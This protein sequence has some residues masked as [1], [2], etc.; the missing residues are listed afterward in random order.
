MVNFLLG[1][2]GSGKTTEI[3]KN[4]ESCVQN[5]ETTFLLVPEQQVYI[6]ECMLAD[7]PATSARYLQVISF[8]TLGEL[9]FSKYGGLTDKAASN[10]VRT[11]V[12]WHTLRCAT[13]GE[14]RMLSHYRG[15]KIDSAF[16][17][18]MLS[19][20]DELRAN[21]ITPKMCEE[22]S[23][24]CDDKALSDKLSDIA[25]IYQLF[26]YNI[27]ECAGEDEANG[28]HKLAKLAS[29][30]ESHDFFADTN[31]FIDSFTSFTKEELNI[32]KIIIS[33]AKNVCITLPYDGHSDE[34]H[35]FSIS[36][37]YK[38]LQ[39]YAKGKDIHTRLKKSNVRSDKCE[40]QTLEKDLW[41]FRI[42]KSS[43]PE[44]S[45]SDRGNIEMYKCKNEY[46]EIWLAGLNIKKELARGVKCSEIALIT[47]NPEAKRGIISAVFSQLKIPY[48]LSERTDLSTTAPA[49]LILSTLRCISHGF[50]SVDVMTLLKTGFLNVKAEDA[51][52]FEDYC[53]TW[54]ISGNLFTVS[55]PWSMN[56][57][58]YTTSEN[59]R[60]RLI[61][62][63]ANEVRNSVISPL[64]ELRN[65]FTINKGNT[66][67]NCRAL[68]AY[69][70]KIK[71]SEQIVTAAEKAMQKDEIKEAGELLRLYDCIISALSDTARVL[72]KA[73]T[74]AEDL[75]TALDIMLR[76][77]D[78]GSVPAISDY[79]TVG[80]AATLRIENIKTAILVGLCEGE[81]PANLSDG[82]IL[83]ETDKAMIEPIVNDILG[84]EYEKTTREVNLAQHEKAI[85]S[86]ELFYVY[87]SM[88]KPSEKLI[89]S[90]NNS[91]V[92][93]GTH[94]PSSA[95]NRITF[96]FPYI[97]PLSFDLASVRAK[98]KEQQQ[99]DDEKKSDSTP[100]ENQADAKDE[101]RAND[102]IE[103]YL[104]DKFFAYNLFGDK[105]SLNKSTITE[106]NKCPYR[107]WC[108]SIL[109]LREQK[110]SE[111]NNADSGTII[112]H[113]M[114][115]AIGQLHRDGILK[116]VNTDTLPDLVD[117]ILKEHLIKIKCP[118]T[119]ST[120][121][122]FSRLRDLSL[123]M[124]K[125]VVDEFSQSSLNVVALEQRIKAGNKNSSA[126]SPMEI[127]LEVNIEDKMYNPKVILEGTIDRIDSYHND[128][129]DE[130]YVR[131]VDYK[132]GKQEYDEE[133]IKTGEDIQLPAYL[134][135]ATLKD[136][137]GLFGI[138]KEPKAA[139]AQYLSAVED[140]GKTSAVRSGF[141]LNEDDFP[142]AVTPSLDKKLLGVKSRTKIE[143]F[144]NALTKDG[145]DKIKSTMIDS[146][147]TTA[148]GIYQGNISKNPSETACKYC[149]L[150]SCCPVAE[151]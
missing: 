70:E 1:R 146:V 26:E 111:I 39:L 48:F 131:V 29:V 12:M 144:K 121:Y 91:S 77:T 84:E 78:M 148:T 33:S 20:I 101:N 117:N 31:V 2:S 125:S 11:L 6:S 143:D 30:L 69:L 93:G 41:N 52:L 80:S 107:F 140:E 108:N 45:E 103:N 124:L 129:T 5:K 9:V 57:N 120:M 74:T 95:W 22:I 7:L 65:Q 94:I 59:D 44:I 35:F 113:V 99:A 75:Y 85:N 98:A 82:G 18:M 66:T 128:E 36:N 97:T 4:I 13:T 40:L 130:T 23:E 58:G 109:N 141:F 116:T 142:K 135:V 3:I 28:E 112:H 37:T 147:K 19:T 42:T 15:V 17:S 88:T 122:S 106:Y 32:L 47:R 92:S 38:K 102:P 24:H 105:L 137:K 50:N 89:L 100:S 14:S 90:T 134:F 83:S 54:N 138:N 49:R 132:T 145:I 133:R 61:L 118:L 87:R 27:K 71:L 56:P 68:Y 53:Y 151:K 73:P 55:E 67:E 46:E 62:K 21:S 34:P 104:K 149:K 60:S 25:A 139:S 79:V 127:E 64:I 123:I 81:F 43:L 8:S 96:L 136:N 76:N 115:Q 51:D 72:E 10:A 86:D 110:V 114:E 119:P 63:T 126:I 16:T 150:K